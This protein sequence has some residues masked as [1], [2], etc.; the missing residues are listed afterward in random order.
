MSDYERIKRSS[1]A[2][3]VSPVARRKKTN[4]NAT[5][6]GTVRQRDCAGLIF[7]RF[8][9]FDLLEDCSERRKPINAGNIVRP[10]CK[11]LTL[12]RPKDHCKQEWGV[13]TSYAWFRVCSGNGRAG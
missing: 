2:S 8:C 4:A 7:T 1:L 11:K 10:C 5:M 13:L 12:S 9:L 6:K 3:K